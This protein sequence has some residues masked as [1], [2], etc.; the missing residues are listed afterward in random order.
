MSNAE[1]D[2]LLL[3]RHYHEVKPFVLSCELVEQ[4]KHERLNFGLRI[5]PFTLRHAQGERKNP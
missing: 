1:H 2:Y 5:F 4:S 3:A